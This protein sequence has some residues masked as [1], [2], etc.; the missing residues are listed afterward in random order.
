MQG[1][2]SMSFP[3]QHQSPESFHRCRYGNSPKKWLK[4]FLYLHLK[5]AVLIFP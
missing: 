2:T 3:A 5:I 4:K 1:L